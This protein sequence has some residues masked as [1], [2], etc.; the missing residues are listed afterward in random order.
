ME[1]R[2]RRIDELLDDDSLIDSV[3]VAMR[4]RFAHSGRRGRYGTPAEV[5][6]RM[7]V[8]K[9]LKDLSYEQ[10]ECEVTGNLVY[11]HSCRIDGGKVPDAKT[12]V[13]LG[14]LLEG[15]VL[16][17]TFDRVV[18]LAIEKRVTRGRKMRVD[19]TVET[20]LLG[21]RALGDPRAHEGLDAR[22]VRRA[23]RHAAPVN[24]AVHRH[25]ALHVA[26]LRIARLH[27]EECGI[28]ERRDANHI[29]AVGRENE[30]EAAGMVPVAGSLRTPGAR[31]R[32]EERHTMG[33]RRVSRAKGVGAHAA[34]E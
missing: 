20:L 33:G 9:H 19:T 14:Q 22:I 7:L 5:A 10:L 27:A 31:R 30:R 23:E 16:R 18:A 25:L 15:D 26:M 21:G 2:L 11:R 13:R 28:L 6:L 4:G 32:K 3:L 12:M 8:L 24:A 1:P 17:G 34:A 29:A